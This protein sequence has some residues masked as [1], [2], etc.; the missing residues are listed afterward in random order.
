V[1]FPA[2]LTHPNLTIEVLLLREDHIRRPQPTTIRGRTRDPGERR[3][4]EL[5]ERVALRTP[6]DILA[7]LPALPEEPFS[8]RELATLVR[9]STLLAQRT[10]Y[11]LRMIGIVEPAGKRGRAPL[12]RLSSFEEIG[13][14]TA[15]SEI[16]SPPLFVAGP[17]RVTESSV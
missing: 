12:Y 5:L 14:S 6:E 8:T 17:R 2:L 16:T 11:C 3:L 13:W 15:K 7:T 10:L 9:C 1:A 4:V